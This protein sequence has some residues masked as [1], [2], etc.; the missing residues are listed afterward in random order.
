MCNALILGQI[1]AWQ[2]QCFV[3]GWTAW[4]DGEIQFSNIQCLCNMARITLDPSDGF[5]PSWPPGET[6]SRW[7][8]EGLGCK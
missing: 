8:A 7:S 3:D 1:R 2:W 5:C 6:S 4:K